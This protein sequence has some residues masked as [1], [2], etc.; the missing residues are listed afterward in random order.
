MQKQKSFA[1]LFIYNEVAEREIVQYPIVSYFPFDAIVIALI[2][3]QQ[4]QKEKKD[5]HLGINLSEELKNL[6][7]ENNKILTLKT[8]KKI[9]INGYVIHG[10]N[11]GIYSK[12]VF[13]KF[14]QNT[15][16]ERDN[17]F[18]KWC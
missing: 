7:T 4:H 6:Y 14:A 18:N 12:L 10:I 13:Y 9:Q 17:L 15:Q 2:L 16:W 5:E 1:F 11:P 3:L 8:L